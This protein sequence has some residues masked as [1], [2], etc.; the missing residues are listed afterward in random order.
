[1]S[2]RFVLLDEVE[3]AQ[4]KPVYGPGLLP[5]HPS[6]RCSVLGV[7]LNDQL[8][9]EDGVDVLTGGQLVDENLKGVRDD[10]HPYGDGALAQGLARK[11]DRAGAHRL[12]ADGDDVMFRHAVGR[13]V[14]A[15]AIDQEVAVGH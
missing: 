14:D 4:A 2:R 8:L 7:E 13:N 6:F 12:R 9:R 3:K 5:W 10:L 11:L 15:H 1:M